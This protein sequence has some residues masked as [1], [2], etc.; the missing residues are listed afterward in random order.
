VAAAKFLVDPKGVDAMLA[1][2]GVGEHLAEVARVGADYARSVAPVLSG[3]YRDSIEAYPSRLEDGQW[4]GS[5][6]AELFTWHWV[7]F[8]SVK[9][10]PYRVLSQ[11]A[12]A[13]ADRA[14]L[15]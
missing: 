3:R 1:Q 12:Q 15:L 11:A 4:V 14:D 2:P 5:F 9:N 10:P 6:G 8:G 13:V 7:E